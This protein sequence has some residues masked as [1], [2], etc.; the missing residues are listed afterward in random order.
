MT[1]R[2]S[3]LS[4][5]EAR[6]NL[7]E[8]IAARGHSLGA[9]SRMIGRNAAYL[10]Q[11]LERGSPARLDEDDRLRLAMFLD[12]DERQLGARDPWKPGDPAP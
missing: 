7:R 1:D 11:Y 10:Q 12:I 8:A 9:L 5:D 6:A 2:H 3:R 4:P